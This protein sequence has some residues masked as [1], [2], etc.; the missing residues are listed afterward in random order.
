LESARL[1]TL[2]NP[3]NPED[4]DKPDNPEIPH[5]LDSLD[6]LVARVYLESGKNGN[7]KRKKMECVCA[8]PKLLIGN[9]QQAGGGRGGCSWSAVS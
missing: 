3:A 8:G 9:L 5:N 7:G 4:L 1:D 2:D 6:N